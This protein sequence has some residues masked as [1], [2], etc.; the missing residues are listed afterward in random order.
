MS[1]FDSSP[2][3][4]PSFSNLFFAYLHDREGYIGS[5]ERI[6]TEYVREANNSILDSLINEGEALLQLSP[7]PWKDI[8]ADANLVL[9]NEQEGREFILK[10][11]RIAE[12]EQVRRKA[13]KLPETPKE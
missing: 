11:L 2:E 8:S 1:I 10:I 4:Y 5:A 6:V 13:Q 7:F 12:D 3:R 9:A